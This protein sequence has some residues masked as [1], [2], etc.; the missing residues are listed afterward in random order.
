MSNTRY[1]RLSTDDRILTESLRGAGTGLQAEQFDSAGHEYLDEV[2]PK[3]WGY[4][5]RVYAD[6][7]YDVWKLC[8][9]PGQAT[10]MHCHPRK[11]TALLCISGEG[12]MRLLERE[13]EVFTGDVVYLAKGVFHETEN[14]SERSLHL[15]EVEVPRNKFDLVRLRDRY[16]RRGE[17]YETGRVD[18]DAVLGPGR[19][20]P[21]SKVRVTSPRDGF[22][23]GV[24]AGLDLISRPDPLLLFAV[25]LD[26]SAAL[27]HA[28]TVWPAAVA[29]HVA[30]HESL[31]L[32]IAA[33]QPETT[34]P[35]VR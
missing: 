6:D 30:L 26:V 11:E 14:T 27:D 9:L 31:Y 35:A 8:L 33:G 23:F 13:Q 18:T 29:P 28:I 16:G 32:T 1:P 34:A 2:I 5:Y 12:R 4:E 7:L 15:I 17:Q 25:S 20:I 24:S 3:P 21:R 19:L 10:S 22:R